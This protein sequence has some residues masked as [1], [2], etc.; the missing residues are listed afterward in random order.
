[1]T[2]L[3]GPEPDT[4]MEE[5]AALDFTPWLR[6]PD[7]WQPPANEEWASLAKPHLVSVRLAWLTLHIQRRPDRNGFGTRRRRD[8]GAGR[9]DWPVS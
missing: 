2:V 1:M 4:A 5:L 3:Q 7:G 9:A 8:Y 6:Q